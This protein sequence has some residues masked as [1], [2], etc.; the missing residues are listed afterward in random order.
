MTCDELER[1]LLSNSVPPG[2]ENQVSNPE[3]NKHLHN[4]DLHSKQQNSI[5]KINTHHQKGFLHNIQQTS[6]DN[7]ISQ[8]YKEPAV[9]SG[10]NFFL[11]LYDDLGFDP[12]SES[13]KALADMLEEEKSIN[14]SN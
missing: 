6:I 3:N 9:S 10:I 1:I 14:S 4:G 11:D 13:S 8:N 7:S 2:F 12:F 5:D